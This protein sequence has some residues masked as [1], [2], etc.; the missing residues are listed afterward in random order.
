MKEKTKEIRVVFFHN[1]F[2]DHVIKHNHFGAKGAIHSKMEN[3]TGKKI[4]WHF[5]GGFLNSDSKYFWQKIQKADML[6]SLPE[7]MDYTDNNMHW[8]HAETKM[9][10]LC[11]QIKERNKN[12]KIFFF[13]DAHHLFNEFQKIGEFI[14][15]FQEPSLLEYIKKI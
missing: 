15:D 1:H 10:E 13:E 7:N 8:Q 3:M 14:K 6:I 2:P 4:N 9:L 5:I 11:Q 12:I